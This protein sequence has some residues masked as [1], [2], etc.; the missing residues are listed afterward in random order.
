MS[1][2]DTQFQSF[3]KLLLDELVADGSIEIDTGWDTEDSKA[4]DD[5]QAIIARRA[6]DL[7]VHVLNSQHEISV[8]ASTAEERLYCSIPD[9]TELPKEQ[10]SEVAP[11]ITFVDPN[12]QPRQISVTLSDGKIFEGIVHYAGEAKEQDEH[13]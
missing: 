2:R 3:A 6:Y 12:T 13:H 8:S 10:E 5:A 11:E 7:A 1:N 9:M 4:Y